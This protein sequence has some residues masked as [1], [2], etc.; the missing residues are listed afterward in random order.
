LWKF[1]TKTNLKEIVVWGTNLGLTLGQ[2]TSKFK[3]M[4]KLT[5]FHYSVLIG[6]LLSDG[7]IRFGHTKK[8]IMLELV[9]FNQ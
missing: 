1:L 5:Y 9:L 3:H 4:F 6:I 8:Q 7:W 2:N